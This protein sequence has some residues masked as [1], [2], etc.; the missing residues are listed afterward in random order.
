MNAYYTLRI[1][2]QA[3]HLEKN[4]FCMDKVGKCITTDIL[5]LY[6][7]SNACKECINHRDDQLTHPATPVI[8]QL[9]SVKSDGIPLSVPPNTQYNLPSMA[10][11]ACL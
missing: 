9:V 10:S 1:A 8:A 5:M 2:A 6:N 4:I 3:T 11:A 7:L